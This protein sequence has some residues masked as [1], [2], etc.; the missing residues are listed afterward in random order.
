MTHLLHRDWVPETCETYMQEIAA[1]AAG[2]ASDDAAHE[3]DRLITLNSKIHDE[4]CI[5]LNPATPAGTYRLVVGLVGGNGEAIP[6]TSGA[7]EAD[8]T[9]IRIIE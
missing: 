7:A 9:E 4:D 8:L 5:N 2:L 3:I 6:M 1:R